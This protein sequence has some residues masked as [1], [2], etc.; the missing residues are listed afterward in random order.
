M[1]PRQAG[2][3]FAVSRWLFVRLL[4]V[5][6]LIAFCSL[7][8]QILGLVGERGILPARDFLDRAWAGWGT[9]ALF[10]LPSL[11]WI[12]TSDEALVGACWAGAALSALLILGFLPPVCLLLLW[13]LYL[14]LSVVGQIF[15]GFQWD[16]LLLETGL[17]AVF[18]A[19]WAKWDSFP[20]K[21]LRP[22][23]QKTVPTDSRDVEVTTATGAW[24]S[25]EVLMRWVLYVLLFKLMFLSG[26]TKILSGDET[27]A[28]ATALEYHYETQPLPP[29]TA[30]YMHQL[31][32]WAHRISL[33]FM[34]LAELV[35]P[36][37]Y[38]GPT[39]W[40][41]IRLGAAAV[42][43]FFQLSLI[44]TGNYTFFNWLTIALCIPLI[45]DRAWRWLAGNRWQLGSSTSREADGLMGPKLFL[46][47]GF[48]ALTL[49]VSLLVLVE[50]M[51][52]TADWVEIRSWL[53]S[54]D[55]V[56]GLIKPFRSINGYGLF[57]V[58]TTQR[59][60]IVVEVS[61]DG[62]TWLEYPFRYKAG[63]VQ[64]RPRFVAPHQPRLDW[65]MWFAALSP[66]ANG[67]WLHILMRRLLEGSPRVA[68]LLEESPVGPDPPRYV[69][70]AYFDYR[71]TPP[72]PSPAG[73][74]WV[75]KRLGELTPAVSLDSFA[76]R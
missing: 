12:S 24:A 50:E 6:Y 26:I 49:P 35:V 65:Q 72:D 67:A 60:E 76:E 57:R 27:W 4:G 15:L 32:A 19:R 17:I 34:W 14:S 30:W 13:T 1:I 39:S 20:A 68:A 45:D 5:I 70:L 22:H 9:Q 48:L 62:E 64:R 36:F 2:I 53:R 23:P 46:C 58:M 3:T 29:W 59:P 43:I 7:G 8:V 51:A 69:R 61:R 16:V 10:Q 71:F 44:A 63:D 28:A 31:P 40:R 56:T 33:A 21:G 38:L 73:D 18:Y 74:W 41:R 75:R 37:A 52:R 47:R 25:S 54:A 11:F 42:T 66:R 55:P